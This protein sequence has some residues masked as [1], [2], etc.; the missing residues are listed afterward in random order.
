MIL[1]IGHD[2]TSVERLPWLSLALGAAILVG[3]FAARGGVGIA[4]DAPEVK[5]DSAL[6]VWLSH[7]YLEPDPALLALAR[8]DE[9]TSE[10]VVQARAAA[11][12]AQVDAVT[13]L[14]EQAEL[15]DVTRIALR[16]SDA[17][18][19]PA[20]PFRRFGWIPAAPRALALAAYPFMHV[21]YAHLCVAV[22]LL[23]LVAPALE[24][25]FGPW[26]FTA[27]CAGSALASAAGYWLAQP[28]ADAPLVGASGMAA[29]LLGAFAVR[30]ARGQVRFAW[31][32]VARM[33]L[34]TG[35][36]SAPAWIALPVWLCCSAALHYLFGEA[37]VETGESLAPSLS[38]LAFGAAAAFG[39]VA[40]RV[41]ER[42]VRRVAKTAHKLDPR[43]ER[44]L[45]AH[46]HGAHEQ[47]ISLATAVL[48]DRPD[49]PDALLAI[50][51][52][53]VAVGR[54][55][56]GASAAKRLIEIHARHGQLAAAA[57]LYAELERA[58]PDVKL[59][60]TVL[61][62]VVP[63]LVVQA[64]R[65]A[66][67][68][69]L[70]AVVSPDNRSL[71]VGQAA[72][73]A[74][75]GAELDPPCALAAARRALAPPDLAP[76]RREK[77][78]KLVRE[79]EA[80]VCDVPTEVQSAPAEPRAVPPVARTPEP[81]PQPEPEPAPEIERASD[82][83]MPTVIYSPS[84]PAPPPPEPAEPTPAKII[85]A[86]PLELD[87]AGLRL[88]IDAAAPSLLVWERIQ[89]VGVG[90]VTGLGA[91][92]VVVIDLA[93]N[94]AE[95]HSGGLEVLR[96]RSDSFRARSLVGGDGSA[97]E[98]LRALL[99][100][101]LARSG[102]VPLPDGGAARGLPFRE[103]PDASSYEREVLQQAG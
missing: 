10:R 88:R 43:I 31:V 8:G 62:R 91:K 5:L 96:L 63:E 2:Q 39:L 6:E 11:A 70:R 69:A 36:F 46:A 102:A 7:A 28:N 17:E 65:E 59:D 51:S 86:V 82:A 85:P 93:L 72:R 79:L 80:K 32:T 98:A 61:L 45:D 23:G 35:T 83:E 42:W 76:E 71:T 52:A 95:S 92:P 14:R 34:A 81:P 55:V 58:L 97:L 54:E 77:L 87:P 57:R 84:A 89:A 18:P 67:I 20:H 78:L 37:H 73:A 66:A 29:G 56:E 75:L 21:G 99:A 22:L 38:A 25:A 44:A 94:W 68:A 30:H 60:A 19:G 13:K 9:A 41:E 74:E 47:A 48:R 16:G 27:L 100:Q 49:D 50:W 4:P 15:D 26:L 64:R 53:E 40:L 103:F 12:S 3:F 101:L 24:D 33:R 1:P 90:L